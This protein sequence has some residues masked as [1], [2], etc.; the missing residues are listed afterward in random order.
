MA[1]KEHKERKELLPERGC[2]RSTSRSMSDISSIVLVRAC[3][4]WVCDHSRAPLC[5][6]ALG[7]L[8]LSSVVSYGAVQNLA[9]MWM[10]LRVFEVGSISFAFLVF[11]CG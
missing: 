6:L 1:A 3:C 4:G 2:V 10:G 7:A 11:F 8:V 5:F 9:A